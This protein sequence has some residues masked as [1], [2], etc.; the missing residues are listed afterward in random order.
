MSDEYIGTLVTPG[1][2]CMNQPTTICQSD[3]GKL[4]VENSA[5][6]RLEKLIPAVGV[7][8]FWCQCPKGDHVDHPSTDQMV[9]RIL[10][11]VQ[12]IQIEALKMQ[13]GRGFDEEG[14]LR[15]RAPNTSYA[16]PGN[17]IKQSHRM[18]KSPT[19]ALFCSE[20]MLAAYCVA[21]GWLEFN[22]ACT[23][24]R[25]TTSGIMEH[26]RLLIALDQQAK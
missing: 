7:G 4:W 23:G 12:A 15:D 19:T 2:V 5:L 18:K 11:H 22:S 26:A 8:V 13:D 10:A 1:R 16:G 21:K 20:A 24:A 14:F 17:Y 3:D 6:K 25:I 9:F